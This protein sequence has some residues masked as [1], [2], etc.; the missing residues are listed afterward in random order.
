MQNGTLKDRIREELRFSFIIPVFN[1]PLEIRELLD[2]LAQQSEKKFEII[3]VDDGS[4]QRAETVCATFKNSLDINY[5]YKENSGPGPSRNYGCTKATGNYFIFLDSDC[6]LPE[7]YFKIIK[8]E[9]HQNYT[10]AFGGP[11]RSHETFSLLQKGISY[12]MTSWLTTGGIRGASEKLDKFHPRSFNMGYSKC[13]FE[14]TKGFSAMR[15]GE[16]IDMSVRI[17]Q[18]GFQTRL[19]K[20]AFVFHKRRTTL[21]QFF[22]Q[23]FNS[24]I[25]RI[26]LYIRHPHTLKIVH[27]LPA[28]FTIGTLVTVILSLFFTP[29]FLIPMGL[30]GI[31]IFTDASVKNKNLKI[32]GMAVVTS[33]V[34]LIG[35]GI[36]LLTAFWKRILLKQ[37]EY[38]AYEKNFYN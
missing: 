20:V 15:F 36:G 35:Y 18:N 6:S 26:H 25:A 5:Y 32:G 21:I 13:V 24:G 4:D 17:L 16:D 12:A 33:Y 34:Q 8:N 10:D 27:V 14:K 1:R 38:A 29:L 30:H 37:K 2:S 22:K 11:D 23:V 31:L 3:I 9:L 28:L 7:D 19:I